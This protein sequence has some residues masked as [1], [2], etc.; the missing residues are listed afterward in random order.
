MTQ[1]HELRWGGFAGIAFLVLAVLAAVLPGIP[2]R[3]TA[4]EDTIT[5]YVAD[6]RSQMLLAAILYAAAAGLVIWFAAAFAEA[7]RE[8]DERSDVHLA[9]L[10][11]SV[12]IGA[13]LFVYGAAM[14]VLA[15]GVETV[16]AATI[17]ALYQGTM[18][19]NVLL[20]FAA[21]LPLAAAGIGVLRTHLMPDWLGYIALAAA[22]VSGLAAFS[23]FFDSGT[24]APGGSVMP[25]VSLTAGGIFVACASVFMVREHLPE[26]APMAMPQA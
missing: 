17:V 21:A 22:A 10:A 1:R 26:V 6:G 15:Y 18:V 25:F 16:E 24:Y 2:P 3:V 13:A 23:I 20:G 5:S 14:G 7:I 19:L 12:L 11:G 8:R 9:I 4:T